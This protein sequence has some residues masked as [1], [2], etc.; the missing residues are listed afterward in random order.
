MGGINLVRVLIGGIVA[1]VVANAGDYLVNRVILVDDGA[2]LVQRLNL[3]PVQVEELPVETQA[4]PPKP[5]APP[6]DPESYAGRLL[7]ARKT[8]RKKMNDDDPEGGR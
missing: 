1:G 7:A 3:D 8:A 4:A 5:A 6:P 2:Q